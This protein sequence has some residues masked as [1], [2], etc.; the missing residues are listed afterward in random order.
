MPK[1]FHSYARARP[2][3]RQEILDR[4]AAG[5]RLTHVCAGDGMPCV[6]SVTGWA[7]KD[8]EFGA[9]LK[10]AHAQGAA[11]RAPWVSDETAAALVARLRAGERLADVLR[12]PAMPSPRTF[13]AWRMTNSL[14]AEDLVQALAAKTE[15]KRARMRGRRRD[16]DPAVGERLYVELWKGGRTL[17]AVLASDPAF[18]S[19]AVLARWRRENPAFGAMLRFVL[20]GWRVKRARAR[21]RLT[22]DVEE[23]ILEGL[24]QGESL[25][26]LSLKPGMP[27]QGAMYNWVRDRPGFAAAVDE[28][29][30]IRAEWYGDEIAAE[31][32]AVTPETLWETKRR[33]ARLSAQETRLRKRPGWKRRRVKRA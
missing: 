11:R 2:Q 32:R 29:C 12:D 5:G 28:A 25:R 30:E 6:E 24:M 1:G 23:T 22:P 9:A 17:R 3:M 8:P 4:V 18:P 7:R 33:I 21:T 13:R 27:S 20:D 19:L 31:A 10:A 14:H 26:S 15:A 16:F